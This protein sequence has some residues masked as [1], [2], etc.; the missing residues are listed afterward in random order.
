MMQKLFQNGNMSSSYTI[1]KGKELND[2]TVIERKLKLHKRSH[3]RL[4]YEH[5]K[6][7]NWDHVSAFLLT[8]KLNT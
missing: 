8:C 7:K 3:R 2:I 5:F 4:R 6:T 1:A